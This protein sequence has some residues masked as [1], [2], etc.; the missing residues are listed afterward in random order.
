MATLLAYD[1]PG[2][3]RELKHCVD[4][5]CALHSEGALQMADLPSALQYRQAADDLARL[6]GAIG[7]QHNGDL[8]EVQVAPISPVISLPE[9]ERHTIERALAATAGERARAA[10]MLG[11]GRTT[12][13]RK[14]KQYG[15]A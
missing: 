2:N 7:P 13:Y 5:M 1:W 8:P 6:T 9:S 3:V 11:I 10:K 4:R 12:L 14:M 15:M